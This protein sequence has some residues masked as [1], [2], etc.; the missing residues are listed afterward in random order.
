[1]RKANKVQKKR[2]SISEP[3]LCSAPRF[4]TTEVSYGFRK[5]S[6]VKIF[7]KRGGGVSRLGYLSLLE[8]EVSRRLGTV[9]KHAGRLKPRIELE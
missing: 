1:M 8:L 6:Q 2:E 4:P 3:L 5:D 9:W 7:F